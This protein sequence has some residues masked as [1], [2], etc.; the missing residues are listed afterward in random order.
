MSESYDKTDTRLIEIRNWALENYDSTTLGQAKM[1]LS[2]LLRE[3]TKNRASH[4]PQS[5]YH[6]A[7]EAFAS[8]NVKDSQVGFQTSDCVNIKV[9]EIK[10]Y[11]DDQP[12]GFVH[13][14]KNDTKAESRLYVPCKLDAAS[15]KTVCGFLWSNPQV[16]RFKI[17]GYGDATTRNDVIVAWFAHRDLARAIGAKLEDLY[18][19]RLHGDRV[20]GSFRCSDKDL[21]GWAPQIGESV[22]ANIRKD[23]L[24]EIAAKNL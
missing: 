3:G 22:G 20:I 10:L 24:D 6:E 4:A 7:I 1:E 17:V 16:L 13:F 19:S 18:G 15:V 9:S 12:S 5:S 11:L 23:L 21:C 2:A 14:I 8:G